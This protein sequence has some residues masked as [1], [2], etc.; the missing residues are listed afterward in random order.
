MKLATD[1]SI[2]CILSMAGIALL[3]LMSFSRTGNS[4]NKDCK[5]PE[6]PSYSSLKANPKLPDPFLMMNG[7]RIT[8]KEEWKCRRAEIAALAQEFEYGYKPNTPYAAS[9]GMF[10]NDSI[11]VTVNDNGKTISFSCKI[12]YPTAGKAPYPA[13]IGIGMSNLN[14]SLLSNLGVAVISFPNNKIANQ[15]NASSRGKGIFYDMFGSNHSAGAL[16]AWAWGVSKLIDALEKTPDAKI[17]ASR[18]GVT[19]C[20]RNGKGAL[21][22]GAYDERI[23]LTIPQESGSGGAVSWRVSDSIKA[24]GQNTQTLSQIVT[25]NCWFR[26]NFS[27][28]GNTASKLPFDQHSVIGLVA[29]RAI[30]I[31]DNDILWLGPESAWNCAHAARTIWEALGV[32]DN[33]GFSQTTAHP[34]CA[35][36]SSQ[37]TELTS[38][39]QKFLLGD[40]SIN[41]SIMKTELG[42]TFEKEKWIDWKVPVLK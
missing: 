16:M 28:F 30:L 2:F 41:T 17:D 11:I 10:R 42:F 26:E 29:P 8:R 40:N 18:L 4:V 3:L 9:T 6:M 34:H 31:I 39:V 19:G 24:K 13:M 25:E 33:M 14:N 21:C 5:L 12:T 38:Y 37:D 20:S 32:P 22:V 15:N 23:K 27:Q 35:Y 1:K 7:K 36:P